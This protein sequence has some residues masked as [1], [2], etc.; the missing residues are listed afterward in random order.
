VEQIVDPKLNEKII[1]E[2]FELYLG[3]AMKC[4]AERGAER[5]SI[6]EVLENLVLAMHLQK[7]EGR[8]QNGNER[9]ND[10]VVLQGNSDLTPGVEF[11]EIM[12]PI[13][14]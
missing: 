3:V 2:C 4:L 14:R 6:G 13:G 10:N 9:I 11:S 7:N 5:P 1:K 12:T 8:V